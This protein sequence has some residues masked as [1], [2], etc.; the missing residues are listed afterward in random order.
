MSES[1]EKTLNSMLNE[2][3]WTRAAISN[4]SIANFQELDAIITQ[5]KKAGKIDEVKAICKEHLCVQKTVL[6]LFIFLVL[7]L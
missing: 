4:Y 3:T 1:V 2:E 6:L 7:F 5:A